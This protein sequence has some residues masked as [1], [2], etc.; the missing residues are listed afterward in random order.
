VGKKI[1]TFKLDSETERKLREIAEKRGKT[2]S[3]V[4]RELIDSYIE[5]HSR[6]EADSSVNEINEILKQFEERAMEYIDS[7]KKFC[8]EHAD[9]VASRNPGA[10]RDFVYESCLWELRRHAYNTLKH[11]YERKVIPLIRPYVTDANRLEVEKKV[12]EIINKAVR[13]LYSSPYPPLKP[14]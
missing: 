12:H 6:E 3:D 8:S 4:L 14:P 5:N 11:Y 13:E 9:I 10:D 2:V 1:V 7:L